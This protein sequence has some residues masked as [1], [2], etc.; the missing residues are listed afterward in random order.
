VK[1]FLKGGHIEDLVVGGLGGIDDVLLS[2]RIR[3]QKIRLKYLTLVLVFCCL[4]L[5]PA[6]VV[7]CSREK[8]S[9]L[10]EMP[11]RMRGSRQQSD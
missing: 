5:G 11:A 10:L 7:F 2:I 4:P 6:R 3:G 9:L 1:E 8:I